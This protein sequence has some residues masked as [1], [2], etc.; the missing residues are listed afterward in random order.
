MNTFTARV[1]RVARLATASIAL[2]VLALSVAMAE[3][4]GNVGGGPKAAPYTVTSSQIVYLD[5]SVLTRNGV[6]TTAGVSYSVPAATYDAY[7]DL[8]YS[9]GTMLMPDG[10]WIHNGNP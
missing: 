8:C 5:G 2:L 1:H 9:E 7:G 3:G 6:Y 10:T 4:W